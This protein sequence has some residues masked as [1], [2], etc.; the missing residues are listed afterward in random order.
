M[1]SPTRAALCFRAAVTTSVNSK[2]LSCGDWPRAPY[3]H[4]GSAATLMDVVNFYTQRFS[5]KFT[6]QEKKD[7]VNFLNTL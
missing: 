6:E 5:I 2:D 1:S 3:F 4:N 7:L